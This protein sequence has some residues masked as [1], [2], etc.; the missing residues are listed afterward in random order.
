MEVREVRQLPPTSPAWL[1]QR[2]DFKPWPSPAESNNH[3]GNLHR[4]KDVETLQATGSDYHPIKLATN[5]NK[6]LVQNNPPGPWCAG[7][8]SPV[9]FRAAAGRWPSALGDSTADGPA[10]APREGLSSSASCL[11]IGK[12]LS[13]LI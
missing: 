4:F 12:I 11:G 13:Q 7:S 10:P 9:P 1:V 2:L 3:K 8:L 5:I 6:D